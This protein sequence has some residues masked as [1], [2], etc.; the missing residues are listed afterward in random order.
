M[1][2]ARAKMIALCAL[3][4]KGDLACLYADNGAMPT[5]CSSALAAPQD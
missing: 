5:V 3:A 4:F 2:A 1:V